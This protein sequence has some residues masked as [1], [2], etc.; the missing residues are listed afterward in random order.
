MMRWFAP[1]RLMPTARLDI[2][3]H[4]RGIVALLLNLEES[5]LRPLAVSLR[6]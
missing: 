5:D 6:R 3:K 4:T 2:S 1:M